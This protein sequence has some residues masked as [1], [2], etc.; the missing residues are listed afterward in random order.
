M[1][2]CYGRKNDLFNQC[3]EKSMTKNTT[4]IGYPQRKQE[5]RKS[6]YSKNHYSERTVSSSWRQ[7][8]VKGFRLLSKVSLKRQQRNPYFPL[9]EFAVI[10]KQLVYIQWSR[11]VSNKKFT[12]LESLSLWTCLGG[13]R[14]D[15]LTF[16][17]RLGYGRL[18]VDTNCIII[19]LN[20]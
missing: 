2:S 11:K 5:K 7:I 16:E 13:W 18:F 8:I 17:P 3:C 1:N 9:Y 4:L 20:C 15:L 10:L 12:F 6:R 19:L 14:I